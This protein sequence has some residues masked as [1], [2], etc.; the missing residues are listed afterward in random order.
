MNLHVTQVTCFWTALPPVL[1]LFVVF[2]MMDD[3]LTVSWD[4]EVAF[5]PQGGQRTGSPLSSTFIFLTE[6]HC[7]DEEV[8]RV[9]YVPKSQS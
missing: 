8:R 1:L 9:D 7:P 4:D 3:M 2:F 5:C 6:L